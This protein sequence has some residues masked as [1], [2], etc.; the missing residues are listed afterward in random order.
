MAAA[1]AFALVATRASSSAWSPSTTTSRSCFRSR[2]RRRDHAALAKTP[3]LANRHAY[4][5]RARSERGEA[6]CRTRAVKSGS[7]VLLSDGKDVGEL[8]RPGDRDR[9]PQGRQ[10]PCLR[11][12]P[13]V[14]AS[15]TPTHLQA[16]GERHPARTPRRR[17]PLRS[18]RS[19]AQL[20]Y[21][22]LERVPVALPVA[23]RPGHTDQG[24]RSKC[25]GIPGPRRPLHDAADF[26]RRRSKGRRRGITIIRSPIT[27]VPRRPD[28]RLAARLRRLPHP[29]PPRQGAHPP[30]RRVRD[31]PGGGAG[32]TCDGGGGGGARGRRANDLERPLAA[33]L[34]EDVEL[35]R[36]SASATDDHAPHDR[37]RRRTRHLVV[38]HRGLSVSDYS[39]ASSRRSSRTC[40]SRGASRGSSALL[41]PAAGQPRPDL[42]RPQ[43]RPQ[44]HRARSP[45]ASRMPRS[46]RRASSSA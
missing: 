36:I 43:G 32:E 18:S 12:R 29:L 14:A 34:E 42:L 35:A 45:S 16:I 15:T 5:R 33:M 24:S 46:R 28:R 41:G 6:C 7:I 22:A 38:D 20:G 26:P 44:L 4:L 39:R 9:E 25:K 17:A 40:S 27:L 23:R 1:R 2:G 37:R 3:S 21:H 11:G 10:G 13:P 31:A 19:T 30:D 8:D